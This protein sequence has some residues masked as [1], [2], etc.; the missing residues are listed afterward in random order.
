[1]SDGKIIPIV[2]RAGRQHG[3]RAIIKGFWVSSQSRE[4]LENLKAG[5]DDEVQAGTYTINDKKPP[6]G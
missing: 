2:D 3:W 4:V 5:K 1:V 6:T